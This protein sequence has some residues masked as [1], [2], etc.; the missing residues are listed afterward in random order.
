MGNTVRRS[1]TYSIVF[2]VLSCVCALP[3]PNYEVRDITVGGVQR[4]YALCSIPSGAGPFP[5]ILFNHGGGGSIPTTNGNVPFWM[6][7]STHVTLLGSGCD[8]TGDC[9]AGGSRFHN[10]GFEDNTQDDTAY[11]S[12]ILDHLA[13]LNDARLDVD[14]FTYSGH[15]N[16]AAAGNMLLIHSTDTRIKGFINHVSQF[17]R[18]NLDPTSMALQECQN[19]CADRP[20]ISA[21][22]D[23]TT[24]VPRPILWLL[25]GQDRSVRPCSPRNTGPFPKCKKAPGMSHPT[26][27]AFPATLQASPTK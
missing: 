21:A 6:P 14:D 17:S 24:I 2:L 7:S 23:V 15:S 26:T 3:C 20:S 8:A 22:K 19:A 13:A 27:H 10:T 16:G 25:G 12:A 18:F 5:I 11:M 1:A 4:V 9:G